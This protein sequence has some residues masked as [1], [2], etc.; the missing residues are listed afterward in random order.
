MKE[1]LL[2]FY[3]ELFAFFIFVSSYICLSLILDYFDLL[4]AYTG[5]LVLIINILSFALLQ[6]QDYKFFK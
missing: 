1:K 3:I 2:K 4:N 6:Q 5:F